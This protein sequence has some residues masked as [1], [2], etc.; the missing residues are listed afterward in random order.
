MLLYDVRT[1][2]KENWRKGPGFDC[3]GARD[4]PPLVGVVKTTEGEGKAAEQSTQ[5]R[6]FLPEQR[7]CH[8]TTFYSSRALSFPR[9][10]Q[11]SCKQLKRD[12][13]TWME[14]LERN[15]KRKTRTC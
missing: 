3:D 9:F 11:G 8:K 10:P 1:K 5:D 7:D 13:L 15:C 2:E 4:S 14:I 12:G 6:G